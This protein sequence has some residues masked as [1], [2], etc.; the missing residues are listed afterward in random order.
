MNRRSHALP[1]Y[2]LAAILAATVLPALATSASHPPLT[3]AQRIARIQ[4]RIGRLEHR[5]VVLRAKGKTH[6][7]AKVQARLARLQAR[8]GKFKSE[9]AH[10]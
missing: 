2:I 5:E 9:I 6:R 8:V 1:L 7:L 4:S 3:P 10:H